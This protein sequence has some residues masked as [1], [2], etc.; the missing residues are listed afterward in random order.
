M[1]N[2]RL[3]SVGFTLYAAVQVTD[4]VT[5]ISTLTTSADNFI[6]DVERSRFAN[7]QRSSILPGITI[8]QQ[9]LA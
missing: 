3:S 1:N 4:N 2:S 6:L 7:V 8:S 9:Q 5:H